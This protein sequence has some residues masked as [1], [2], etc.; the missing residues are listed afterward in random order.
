MKAPEIRERVLAY[1]VEHPEGLRLADLE[2]YFGMARI[3][4]ARMLRKMIDENKV[5]KEDLLYFAR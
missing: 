1:L 2:E 5:R 3:Q 4:M